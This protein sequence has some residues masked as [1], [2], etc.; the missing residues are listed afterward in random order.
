[1]ATQMIKG[2]ATM[3]LRESLD[4]V[5]DEF[6]KLDQMPLVK[7]VDDLDDVKLRTKLNCPPE[8]AID[9]CIEEIQKKLEK[10]TQEASD[11]QPPAT[12]DVRKL[13]K[14]D[15]S[16]SIEDCVVAFGQRETTKTTKDEQSIMFCSP[17]ENEVLQQVGTA[18]QMQ[19]KVLTLAENK[20]IDDN[21][22]ASTRFCYKMGD[23]ELKGI[24]SGVLEKFVELRM[25]LL[26]EKLPLKEDDALRVPSIETSE[27]FKKALSKVVS[28]ELA[29]SMRSLTM[30]ESKIR[31]RLEA[32]LE[33]LVSTYSDT[34]TRP[35]S[36]IGT[37]IPER[38]LTQVT[39]RT[40]AREA[41]F[42]GQ[43]EWALS[44]LNLQQ[45]KRMPLVEKDGEKKLQLWAGAQKPL[46]FLLPKWLYFV[47][48]NEPSVGLTQIQVN[49]DFMQKFRPPDVEAPLLDVG[50]LGRNLTTVAQQLVTSFNTNE[51]L[52]DDVE[53]EPATVF[54]DLY[55]S[56][57]AKLYRHRPNEVIDDEDR[58]FYVALDEGNYNANL[59]RLSVPR[60]DQDRI[61]TTIVSK[62]PPI[63]KITVRAASSN[64]AAKAKALPQDYFY[65]TIKLGKPVNLHEMVSSYRP[66]KRA[67]WFLQDHGLF[68][69]LWYAQQ[70]RDKTID[71]S[72]AVPF[73]PFDDKT[74]GYY[75]SKMDVKLPSLL[76]NANSDDEEERTDALL[77][78]LEAKPT[79]KGDP[80]KAIRKVGRK[81]R[82]SY[83]ARW[84]RFDAILRFAA[85]FEGNVEVEK[86][87][88]EKIDE[89]LTGVD[90][91]SSNFGFAVLDTLSEVAKQQLKSPDFG[92]NPTEEFRRAAA[93]LKRLPEKQREALVDA[94]VRRQ[95]YVFFGDDAMV[96][97]AR[98]V[99]M[100]C[101][102]FLII[103]MLPESEEAETFKTKFKKPTVLQGGGGSKGSRAGEV[104]LST[105]EWNAYSLRV[106][107]IKQSELRTINI[108]DTSVQEKDAAAVDGK[109]AEALAQELQLWDN[110]L[111]L[112][113]LLRV[114]K[115]HRQALA[116][117][118]RAAAPFAKEDEVPLQWLMRGSVFEGKVKDLKLA[119]VSVV[120]GEA[121]IYAAHVVWQIWLDTLRSDEMPAFADALVLF[122][123]SNRDA[124]QKN[125]IFTV[126]WQLHELG[127]SAQLTAEAQKE[128]KSRTK[129]LSDDI[130]AQENLL[131][132]TTK[133]EANAFYVPVKDLFEEIGAEAL[134]ELIKNKTK[135]HEKPSVQKQLAR[136][137][138][139]VSKR[140][141][142]ANLNKSLWELRAKLVM[143]QA[144]GSD[145]SAQK[146]REG[147]R[148]YLEEEAQLLARVF[149]G[150]GSLRIKDLPKANL[151]E[152]PP[153]TAEK[154]K[155]QN[156]QIVVATMIH[157][158]KDDSKKFFNKAFRL[159]QPLRRY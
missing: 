145:F 63:A 150:G 35:I 28:D 109:A 124:N 102:L 46:G 52:P 133:I 138:E 19:Q 104:R 141:V 146:L 53:E 31:N 137:S 130:T 30:E 147:F 112:W 91:V 125:T 17:N 123:S 45:L 27:E 127:D 54:F 6:E 71:K 58:S 143:Y 66:D 13:L 60:Y 15:S 97:E 105:K 157:E 49:R 93:F 12:P 41:F 156:T 140:N 32:F 98:R 94:F 108:F 9:E 126:L 44:R 111:P 61:Q 50:T 25:K 51:N 120:T 40:T 65:T 48:E 62:T 42:E 99:K 155:E 121:D 21:F 73:M 114:L 78:M 116:K 154:E 149:G 2:G 69:P 34:Q 79:I 87:T 18:D 74:V 14:C 72:R 85:K 144:W 86:I 29:L 8:K 95:P 16:Q 118:S 134:N 84:N 80:V 106:A 122:R 117:L 20:K 158:M 56:M 92:L 64:E 83:N 24:L 57:I 119:S 1:M 7:Q 59:K 55:R 96:D 142:M 10:A 153:L 43:S 47:H 67:K 38:M 88:N 90:S 23:G 148:T 152:D 110:F 37:E 136:S 101:L 70:V 115:Q 159:G 103:G 131:A 82:E 100:D 4:Q 132:F 129:T 22:D 107:A 33:R 5:L 68:G 135:T 89:A 26:R 77:G 3:T 75:S 76:K 36:W 128:L 11:H 151:L 39:G 113:N 139:S 81:E